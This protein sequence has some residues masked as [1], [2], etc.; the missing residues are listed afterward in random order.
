MYNEHLMAFL[1]LS[2]P[3]SYREYE[4]FHFDELKEEM[5]DLKFNG[6]DYKCQRYC[7]HAKGDMS[8]GKIIDGKIVC[9]THNWKFSL[10]DGQCVTNK[11]KLI[12][13][14]I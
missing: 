12:I 4:D 3:V 1:K 10:P 8:K 13:E 7:P 2:D 11:S 9:P 6:K 5:F 14:A